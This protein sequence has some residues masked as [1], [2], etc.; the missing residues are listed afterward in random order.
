MDTMD[1]I[2]TAID[3]LE[4]ALTRKPGFGVGTSTS[5]TTLTSGLR[6]TT[7]DGPWH[8]D[9]DLLDRIG[10]EGSAPAPSVLMRAALGSCMAMSYRLRA[11]K[12]GVPLTSVRVTVET[13]SAVAG[14]LLTDTSEP[15]GFRSVRFHVE[16]DSPAANEDVMRVIDEGD[17]LSPVLD[18]FTRSV[19]VT[20]TV[21]LNAAT[22]STEVPVA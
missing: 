6:C 15:A 10:G 12:H 20:R 9:A 16:I 7:E 11:A 13:E 2:A 4:T 1:T 19:A 22:P 5:V 14:M 18:L 3:R 21:A 8:T 17:Q